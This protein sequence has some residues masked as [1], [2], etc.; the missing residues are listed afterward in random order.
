M[1]III[2]ASHARH[3]THTK[4]FSLNMNLHLLYSIF[5]TLNLIKTT[6][7]NFASDFT[8]VMSLDVIILRNISVVGCI[9]II[10]ATEL[11]KISRSLFMALQ[12]RRR[13]ISSSISFF[14]SAASSTIK[15]T[16]SYYME[17]FCISSHFLL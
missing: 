2:Y 5:L 8:T 16:T 17:A 14:W 15:V 4:Y 11:S 3:D 10:P 7:V 6:I 9:L 1:V 12:W 13:C